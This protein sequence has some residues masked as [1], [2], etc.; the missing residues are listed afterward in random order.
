MSTAPTAR[1]SLAACTI[2]VGVWTVLLAL[3]AM[4]GLPMQAPGAKEMAAST[5]SMQMH[6]HGADS[7]DTA[8]N[9]SDDD[10]APSVA[11]EPAQAC[12]S[13][14]HCTAT[15]RGADA[16]A[17]PA[18]VVHASPASDRFGK[19]RPLVAPVATARPPDLD[20]LQISRT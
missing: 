20:T 4:H 19:A 1:R 6:A 16:A 15:L 12:A 14:D 10:A 7:A 2:A 3:F 17:T 13:S 11:F 8:P 18:V 5:V 9:I